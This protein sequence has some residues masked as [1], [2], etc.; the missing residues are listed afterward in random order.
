MTT[1]HVV[2][3]GDIDDPASPS[4]GN[5]YDRRVCQGLAAAGWTVRE[6]PLPGDWPRPGAGERAALAGVLAGLPDGALVL[7]DGLVASTVPEVLAPQ[8][9]RLRLVPLVHL[10]LET[11]A[12]AAA[13][14]AATAVVTTSEWTRRR[15]LDR[16]AL[17]ADRVRAA[18]PGVDP[19]PPTPGSA[20]GAALLC[21]AAV[22]PHKGHDVLAAALA[23]VADLPWTC[24]C[25]GALTRDP[26]F[27]DRLRRQLT[28]A[29]LTGRVRLLGARTGV[30]LH[31]AYARA[32][33]LVLPSRGET[34]G[35]VV[36]EALARGVPVLGTDAGGLPEALGHA[37]DGSRPGLLVPPDDPDALAGALRRWLTD[38]AQ[39]AR[40]RRSARD[41]RDTLTDWAVTSTRLAA[42]LKE[43]TAA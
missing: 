22:T 6:H 31:E 19:A 39:R 24:D 34:Y 20:A 43:T 42:A 11:D 4:G 15:L 33:L 3:P 28:D 14:A 2:L 30:A 9:R 35:M 13:L 37:P 5:G 40:L 27:V 17:P 18:P 25:V 7:L 38:P 32:D 16:Y 26:D 41:R 21:V 12:E 1:L 10:P 8:T 29:G 23:T 36:T